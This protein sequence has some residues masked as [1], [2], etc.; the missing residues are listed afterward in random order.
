MLAGKK[1]AASQQPGARPGAGP[2]TQAEL[3]GTPKPWRTPTLGERE[4]EEGRGEGAGCCRPQAEPSFVWCVLTMLPGLTL[5]A[6]WSP[7]GG[8]ELPGPRLT[9]W[10]GGSPG[11]SLRSG[12]HGVAG[13]ICW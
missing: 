3:A 11:E 6:T 7:A 4:G 8:L 1:A 13:E 5:A 9:S 10:G 12:P 2:Q